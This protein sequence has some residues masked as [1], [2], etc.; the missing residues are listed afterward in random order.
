MGAGAG[1]LTVGLE[2]MRTWH[3]WEEHIFPIALGG[4]EIPG[5]TR[6]FGNQLNTHS[7]D[8]GGLA[9]YENGHL[10]PGIYGGASLG[11]HRTFGGGLYFTVGRG[12]L[13]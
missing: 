4:I 1:P 6:V 13:P 3:D 11:S 8:I 10:S 12:R 7:R 9:Q 2:A 5:A